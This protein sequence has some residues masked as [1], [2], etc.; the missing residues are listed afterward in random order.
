[1]LQPPTIK[2]EKETLV[3]SKKHEGSITTGEGT[4][5]WWFSDGLGYLEIR[6][7]KGKAHR[8]TLED[9]TIWVVVRGLQ[10]VWLEL[11]PNSL[12]EQNKALLDLFADHQESEQLLRKSLSRSRVDQIVAFYVKQYTNKQTIPYGSLVWLQKYLEEVHGI[13]VEIPV[14]GADEIR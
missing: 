6:P 3:M 8:V 7:K 10:K 1:V 11:N 13:T 5:R 9:A 4:L 12:G 14:R 2:K